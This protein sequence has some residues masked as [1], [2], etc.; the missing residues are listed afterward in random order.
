M[1]QLTPSYGELDSLIKAVGGRNVFLC[2]SYT[3]KGINI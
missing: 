2:S 3:F 1:T